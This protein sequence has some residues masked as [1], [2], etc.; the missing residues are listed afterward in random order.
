[1]TWD[2]ELQL[3]LGVFRHPDSPSGDILTTHGLVFA[4]VSRHPY[5]SIQDIAGGA[6]LSRKTVSEIIGDLVTGGYVE[7]HKIGTRTLYRRRLGSEV[8]SNV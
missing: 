5:R 2:K 4:Y 1:M 6:G 8:D 7:S 3:E